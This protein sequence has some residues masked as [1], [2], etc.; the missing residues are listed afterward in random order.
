M[1]PAQRTKTALATECIKFGWETFQKRP[2]FL[3]GI[4]LLLLIIPW[5]LNTITGYAH[6]VPGIILHVVYWIVTVFVWLAGISLFLRAHDDIDGVSLHVLWRPELFFKYLGVSILQMATFVGGFV[7][8]VIPGI[9]FGLMFYFAG[10][11]VVDRGLG[12]VE[13]MKESMRMTNG[14]KW[15]LFLLVV[16]SL[17]LTIIGL[18]CLI[19]GVLVAMPIVS[20]AFVHAY[21][22]LQHKAIVMPTPA[23]VV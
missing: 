5:I 1:P 3:V 13:A 22:Q 7:L 19:V 4:N 15:E 12:P 21:R 11:G 10:Y 9:I 23:A 2:W 18:L 17:G 6:G 8:L 14:H 16:A 20:L